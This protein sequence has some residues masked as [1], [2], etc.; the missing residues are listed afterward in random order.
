MVRAGNLKQVIAISRH[1]PNFS[2]TQLIDQI[3]GQA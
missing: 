3:L 1:F 2:R